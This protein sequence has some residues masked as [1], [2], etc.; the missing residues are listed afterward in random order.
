[1]AWPPKPGDLLP[2]ADEAVGVQRKLEEYSLV[3]GHGVGGPKATGFRRILGITIDHAEDLAAEI[4]SQ[5][6]KTPVAS[7]RDNTF[8]G[9]N[10]VVEFNLRGVGP[11][12][13]RSVRLRTVWEVAE[14][15]SAPRLVSVY[16]KK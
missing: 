9:M 3:E 10:C 7:V 15:G 6:L 8:R 11:Y 4:H 14:E 1:M 12:S 2:R 16:L 13:A 5:I